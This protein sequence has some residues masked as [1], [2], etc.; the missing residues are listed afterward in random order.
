MILKYDPNGRKDLLHI[1]PTLNELRTILYRVS[2]KKSKTNIRFLLTFQFFNNMKDE[3][4]SVTVWPTFQG[5]D[6]GIIII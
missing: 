6:N 2:E 4:I 5:N 1:Q 3:M